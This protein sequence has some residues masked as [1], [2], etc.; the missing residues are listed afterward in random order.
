MNIAVGAGAWVIVF[1]VA[2][3]VYFLLKKLNKIIT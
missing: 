2:I 1:L 3:G